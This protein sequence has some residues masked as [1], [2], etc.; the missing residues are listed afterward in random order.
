[1]LRFLL[2]IAVLVQSQQLPR[3]AFETGVDLIAVDVHV[4]DRHGKP[5][6]DLKADD[7]EVDISPAG[8]GRSRRCSSC[9]TP[10]R[11]FQ[12]RQPHPP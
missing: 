5:I 12:A 9:R 8:A 10:S 4:V 11:T 2:A 7:F 3:P 6:A 1:M